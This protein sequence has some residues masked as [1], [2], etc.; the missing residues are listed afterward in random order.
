MKIAALFVVYHPDIRQLVTNVA[1][2]IDSVEYVLVWRNSDENFPSLL[3]AIRS[4]CLAME[5][6][7]SLLTH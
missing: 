4:Y 3:A 1:A 7:D 6:T 5:K 2:V